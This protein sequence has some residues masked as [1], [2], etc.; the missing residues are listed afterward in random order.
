MQIFSEVFVMML[1]DVPLPIA[2]VDWNS[3]ILPESIFKYPPGFWG[4]TQSSA[5]PP[6]QC[7]RL[8]LTPALILFG[9]LTS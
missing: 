4:R 3:D 2:S 9:A 5:V 8:P 7:S 6:L 1:I